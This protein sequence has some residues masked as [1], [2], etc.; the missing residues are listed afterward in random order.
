MVVGATVAVEDHGWSGEEKIAPRGVASSDTA[1]G[2]P[3]DH[4]ARRGAKI[5]GVGV[6]GATADSRTG[7]IGPGRDG[8]SFRLV[9]KEAVS[10]TEKVPR[11]VVGKNLSCASGGEIEV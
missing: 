7:I 2:D 1:E 6:G 4:C 9:G 3:M 8:K 10:K 11:S 5:I